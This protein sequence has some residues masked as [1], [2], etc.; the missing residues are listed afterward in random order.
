[1]GHDRLARDKPQNVRW[2]HDGG[3]IFF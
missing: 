3:G 2:F 1:M